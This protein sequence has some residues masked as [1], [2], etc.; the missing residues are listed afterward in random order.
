MQV[1]QLLILHIRRG[2]R[3]ASLSRRV[4][5]KRQSPGSC[6]LREWRCGGWL[7]WA[8]QACRGPSPSRRQRRQLRPDPALSAE[9]A[10]SSQAQQAL[11]PLPVRPSTASDRQRA[12]TKDQTLECKGFE[13][14]CKHHT[15]HRVRQ[16]QRRA[17]TM[18]LCAA[19]P[20]PGSPPVSVSHCGYKS[21]PSARTHI[22]IY[23]A[24]SVLEYI[25]CANRSAIS[26]IFSHIAVIIVVVV[27]RLALWS[28]SHLLRRGG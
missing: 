19:V 8:P 17:P 6:G 18:D 22:N 11:R 14:G 2:H 25:L 23:N 4:R 24:P 13:C 27:T 5:M 9:S 21:C 28:H 16:G 1:A 26:S 15:V 3:Q 12:G 20:A 10:G 7:A